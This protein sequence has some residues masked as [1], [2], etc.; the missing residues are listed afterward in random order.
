MFK[1][2]DCRKFMKKCTK[3]GQIKIMSSFDKDS[4]MK[5]KRRN[6]C[7]KCRM[8]A[9][10]KHK[11]IC[12]QCNK[13]Y[14]SS[15]KES[16]F[17]SIQC[18]A[19]W[20]RDNLKGESNPCF[21]GYKVKC[22]ICGKEILKRKSY[23]EKSKHHYCSKECSLKGITK[24]NSGINNSKYRKIEFKCEVCGKISYTNPYTYNKFKHHYCS[25]E[26]TSK[27]KSIYNTGI[28]NPNN[29][30]IHY[31]CDICGKE[32]SM[33]KS[34]YNKHEHHYCSRECSDKGRTLFLS[35]VN[36]KLYNPN[37]SDEE[38]NDKRSSNEYRN[39]IIS[40][41][42]RDNY[43]CQ[44]TGKKGGKLVVHHL[45]GYNW[46]KEHRI[47]I[48]NAITLSED[49]HKLF[50]KLYR[51]GNNTKEQFEEFKQRYHNGEFKEVI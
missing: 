25:R 35:G 36:A 18:K 40:V 29:T 2:K 26:C 39:F 51:N 27:G 31:K 22:D 41:Y 48:N 5:D 20:Q 32:C 15:K 6:Q 8:K 14:I 44:I 17:C 38:R 45:N 19:T 24:F 7:K 37:I 47:D 50:H 33:K 46:D 42:E 1:I 11:H 28:N 30:Q 49:I 10:L 13:E 16:S 21:N 3:C 12:K 9:K 43:T 34:H 23:Y 4:K